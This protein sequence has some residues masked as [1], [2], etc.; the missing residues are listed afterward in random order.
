MVPGLDDD[1]GAPAEDAALDPLGQA[2]KGLEQGAKVC[3]HCLIWKPTYQDSQG[4]WLGPCRIMAGRG[5]LP[6]T[7]ASCERFLLRGSKVP[8][9][10][11]EEPTRRRSV[12]LKGPVVRRPGAA[13]ITLPA[14]AARRA[15]AP[16]VEL[17]DL[18]AMT[19]NELID[20]LRDALGEGDLP[21]LAG[22]W[23]GG[24]I[25]LKPGNAE[26]QAKEI[27]LDAL[28]HKV[29][30]IRDRLRV[31][32]AK[33]NGHAKLSDA[34]KVELQG[35][36]TKCYGSLTTFNVLF[37]EKGDQFVGERGKDD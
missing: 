34:E 30:M 11:P 20:I 4:R 12:T 18:L 15:P 25:V 29:V 17:G 22:K 10:A 21:A 31:L 19:R 13:P 23:E 6:A 27:P 36:V 5:D 26:L 35:Y 1:D 28:F 8:T 32:E 7:A 33:I 2:L 37:R 9:A 14:P 16:D 24:A 3:G